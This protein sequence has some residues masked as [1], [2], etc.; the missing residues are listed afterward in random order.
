MTVRELFPADDLVARWVFSLSAVL[1]D[2]A[3]IESLFADV[4]RND[5][6]ALWTGH[7]YRQLIARLYEAE[8]P[9]I[10]VQHHDEVRTFLAGVP[11]ARQPLEFLTDHYVPQD[12]VRQS[13]VRTT[14]G[15]MRHRTVHHSWPSSEEL[16]Q[17]LIDAGDEEARII[18]N[19]AEEWLH[20]EWP[21]AAAL[22]SVVGDLDNP[23]TKAEFVKRVELAQTILRQLVLLLQA[24]LVSHVE[25][26]G[27]DPA[28][29]MHELG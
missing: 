3:L 22:R 7:A 13:K 25:R 6:G 12:G 8:R 26:L 1:E 19:R 2:L 10:A 11:N 27:I 21:E 16:R 9:I 24:V 23:A 28:R 15:G 20:H 5:R 17:A 4:L 14:Y 18:V 29:L